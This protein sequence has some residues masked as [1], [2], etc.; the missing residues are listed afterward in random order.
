MME[1]KNRNRDPEPM[2]MFDIEDNGLI[3]GWILHSPLYTP[4]VYIYNKNYTLDKQALSKVIKRR[5]RT[6]KGMYF[7]ATEMIEF[8]S[9]NDKATEKAQP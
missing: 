3:V 6:T 5:W 2:N 1:I 9:N 8:E 7:L 4:M